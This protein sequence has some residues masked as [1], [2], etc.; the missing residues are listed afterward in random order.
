MGG[1]LST[2]LPGS[3]QQGL[4]REAL[5]ALLSAPLSSACPRS[6]LG[7]EWRRGAGSEEERLESTDG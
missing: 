2:F 3:P 5:S 6:F 7:W 4:Q 1:P